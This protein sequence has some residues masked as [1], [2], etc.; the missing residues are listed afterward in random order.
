MARVK[1]DDHLY[2][3]PDDFKHS[4][5]RPEILFGS[6]EL[7]TQL[8]PSYREGKLQLHEY[9][10]VPALWT[11]LREIIDNSLDELIKYGH[12]DT[13]RIDFDPA[14]LV[15][16]VE[17]NGR[18]LP[19]REI[20]KLGKGP[21]AS[22]LLGAAR[23]GRNFVDQRDGAG[24]N[25]VGGSAVNF[26]SEFFEIVVERDGTQDTDGVK[27]LE[28]RWE[29]AKSKGEVIHKTKGPHVIRGS[30]KRSGTKVRFRPSEIVYPKRVLPLEFVRDRCWDIAV[31]NPKIKVI[32][33]GE[34]LEPTSGK[35]P[36]ISTYFGDKKASVAEVVQEE[37]KTRFYIVPGFDETREVSFA[38]V[39]NIP[40]FAGGPHVD[41]FRTLYTGTVIEELKRKTKKEDLNFTR[42]M[43][44]LGTL[45]Y[46]VTSMHEP[47]FDSQSKTKLTSDVAGKVRAGYIESD[48]SSMIRRNPEWVDEVIARARAKTNADTDREIKKEQ[49]KIKRSR[50]VR[51]DDASQKNRSDCI[52]FVMEGDSAKG[53]L[54]DERED[55]H[56]I[57]P[58]KG[59]I[60]NARQ[61]SPMDV[62]KD[63]AL[64]DLMGALGLAIGT[65][66]IRRRLRY[67]AVYIATD[68]DEDGKNITALLVNF[69]YQYWPELFRGEPFIYRFCTPYLILTKGK[70]TKYVYAKDYEEFQQ[71]PDA[72][73]GWTVIRAKGLGTLN[74]E[75]WKHVLKSPTLIPL[76]DDGK[77]AE[78]L[79][80]IFDGD[81]AEDRKRWLEGDK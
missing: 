76:M 62:I 38:L 77:L 2:D 60:M 30:K 42:D 10:W 19:I 1:N 66:A 61:N 33:N 56:G 50:I 11:M 54:S 37:F 80:L 78:T 49:R 3:R 15:A 18:G 35:D 81:R 41:T 55:Y 26:T 40:V 79:S 23:S 65:P 29:E 69:F 53:L 73:K 51:L 32:L 16:T 14:T 72:Y 17:D 57:L 44:A 13:L 6:R 31:V 12:G 64:S 34:R 8:L 68:E 22:I 70:E 39:N 58:M 36:I 45:I 25:G 7:H 75:A 20:A 67:G 63:E 48:I 24:M 74:K 43:V 46:A 5:L 21:A 28:Q 27:H 47:R 9:T 59:K 4:R 71:N 52:L